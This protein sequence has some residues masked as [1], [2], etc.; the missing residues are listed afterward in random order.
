MRLGLVSVGDIP[1]EVNDTPTDNLIEVYKTCLEIQ[2]V[3]ATLTVACLSAVQVGIPWV[4]SVCQTAPK[5]HRYFLN[6]RFTPTSDEKEKQAVRFV[7]IEK[8]ESRYFLVDRFKSV[9]YSLH[10]LVVDTS[11]NLVPRTGT[12][13]ALGHL[14]QHECEIIRGMFPHLV[15]E[16]YW[17]KR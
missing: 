2:R 1:R 10:E 14:V 9:N 12:D 7:N 17:I 6:Y 3:L 8:G 5:T 16:E 11:V 13:S 15:G 4:L